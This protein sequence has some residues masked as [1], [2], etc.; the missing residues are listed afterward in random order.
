MA[1][2]KVFVIG[3]ASSAKRALLETETAAHGLAS[4]AGS[5]LAGFAKTAAFA[6]GAA[7][8]GAVAVSLKAGYS[9]WKESATVTAQTGAVLKSTGGAAHVTMRQVT[10]LSN[11]LLAKSGVDDE[12]IQSGENMLLTF[13]NIRN[14]AG[15]GNDIFTQSTKALLDMSTATGQDMRKSAIQ[16]GKALNDPVKGLT[17]L[18]RV[19]VTFSQG[20]KD[21]IAKMVAAGN[22]MGAQKVILRELNKEFGGSAAALG[23]TLPG[24]IN[25]AKEAFRN[26]AGQMFQKLLPAFV[27][28]LSWVNS[29][30]PQISAVMGAVFE[31]IAWTIQNVIGPALRYLIQ[32]VSMVVDYVRAHWPQIKPVIVQVLTAVGDVIRGWVALIREIWDR[33]GKQIIEI[34]RIAWDLVKSTVRNGMEIIRGIVDLIAGLI[35]GD[36]SRVWNGITEIV[37][38]AFRQIWAIIHAA[39]ST[40]GVVA[41]RVGDAIWTGIKAGGE[42]VINWI[43]GKLNGLVDAYN[44]VLGWVTGNISAI[45]TVGG[46]AKNPAGFGGLHGP[47]GVG[48]HA[49]GGIATKATLGIFGEAGPE[50][51]IPLNRMGQFAPAL[52]RGGGGATVNVGPI[53]VH[54]SADAAFAKKLAGELATQLRGGRVPAFQQAIAAI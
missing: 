11:A 44:A 21:T 3:D 19:G 20:Q 9:E 43:I 25:I 50:A 14:E 37:G 49:M 48:K 47:Q 16:L 1:K 52:T 54:G 24:Q 10:D 27:Q 33:F 22:T 38:G 29:H 46:S 42:A 40:L 8:I 12:V 30:W 34:A 4:R 17:S 2:L 35:H 23:K 53:I 45:P 39:V 26:L 5:A 28:V 13:R 15:K 36:W 41:A 31:G 7:G 51:L 18:T 6:A 32:G